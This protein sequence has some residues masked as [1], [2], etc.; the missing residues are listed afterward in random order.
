MIECLCI[1]VVGASTAETVVGKHLRYDKNV[2]SFSV[3][4]HIS[5]HGITAG[6]RL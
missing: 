2:L 1:P 6:E 5:Q 4:S 3:I